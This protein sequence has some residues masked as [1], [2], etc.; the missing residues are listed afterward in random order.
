ML[1]VLNI[2]HL[3]IHIVCKH[4]LVQWT[5][6]TFLYAAT[7]LPVHLTMVFLFY[8]NAGQKIG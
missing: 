4:A 8:Y 6:M 5:A 3:W 1:H 7:E 2:L